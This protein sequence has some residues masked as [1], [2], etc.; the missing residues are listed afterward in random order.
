M[1]T[2]IWTVQSTEYPQSII[3]EVATFFQEG[4][5]VAFPTETVYGLGADATNDEAVARIFE[6]KGRPSDNPLIVHVSMPEQM[7][8]FADRGS[9]LAQQMIAAFAPGPI[10]FI[11]PVTETSMLST[12]VTAGLSTVAVRIP[13]H[14][15]ARNL[16][17]ST[18]LPIAAPSANSS[19]KPSPTRAEHVLQDLQGRIAGVVDGGPT[20][21]GIESTVVDCTGEVPII[22]RPGSITADQIRAVIGNV[23][24]DA[25]LTGVTSAPKSPGMKYTHYAPDA[26]L[27]LV[28]GEIKTLQVWID[29]FQ[30]E[31]K[32]VGVLTT[33]DSKADLIADAVLTCGQRGDI[34]TVAK[35]LY[36]TLR[37]FNEQNV[38][39]IL[40]ETFPEDGAGA[41][42]M[43]R[44]RKAAGHSYL[45]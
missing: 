26:P 30:G 18:Q 45:Y 5:V 7:D 31:G 36:D 39:V 42:L 35:A 37:Q 25:G 40:C 22:L 14:P 24:L 8:E 6:A 20:E 43:N 16:L 11:L 44:L 4:K 3:N 13:S 38:D 32:R 33:V 9:P 27:Y 28:E 19:G 41:A 34:A 2:K 12:R 1:N 10:S 15:V 29:R 21:E 17:E 23:E